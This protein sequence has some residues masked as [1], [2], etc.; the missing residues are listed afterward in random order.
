VALMTGIKTSLVNSTYIGFEPLI[1]VSITNELTQI[2]ICIVGDL[3]QST[4]SMSLLDSGKDE[5]MMNVLER[6]NESDEKLS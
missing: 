1:I 4:S 3:L 5:N 6:N 2:T